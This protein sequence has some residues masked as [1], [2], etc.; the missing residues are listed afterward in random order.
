MI[1]KLICL[2]K[3][4][5]IRINKYIAISTLKC[6]TVQWMNGLFCLY[7]IH[8]LYTIHAHKILNAERNS[9]RHSFSYQSNLQFCLKIQGNKL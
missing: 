5:W 4:N 3:N 9:L 7:I 2:Q 8:W 6:G 1:P